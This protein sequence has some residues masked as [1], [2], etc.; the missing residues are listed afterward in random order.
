MIRLNFA[1]LFAT[2]ATLA[3]CGKGT[4]S[5]AGPTA[6][7]GPS[8]PATINGNG[9]AVNCGAGNTITQNPAPTPAT[10]TPTPA[11][12]TLCKIA[13]VVETGPDTIAVGATA[14]YELTPF[15]VG[16]DGTPFK[17]ADACNE[18]RA[19]LTRW[20]ITGSSGTVTSD[21]GCQPLSSDPPGASVVCGFAARVK[22]TA[23]GQFGLTAVVDQSG[24]TRYIN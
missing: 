7:G 16:A 17:I 11:L 3:A 12:S 9:N 5:P 13:Y 4:D 23:T 21:T 10:P 14:T 8:C 2:I 15:G 18:P 6:T 20:I 24:A 22:R 1:I 19:P